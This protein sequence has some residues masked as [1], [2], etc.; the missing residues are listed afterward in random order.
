MTKSALFVYGGWGGHEPKHSAEIVCGWL[1][2]KNWKIELS[3]NLEIFTDSQT[4]SSFD[5]IVPVWTGGELSKEQES[6]LESAV[7][8]GIGLAGWHGMADAFGN[9][10][11]Y[12]MAVGGRFVWHPANDVRINIKII[13]PNDPIMQGIDDFSIT[14]ELYYMHID[15]SNH[16]L[17]DCEFP[18]DELGQPQGVRMPVAWRRNWGKGR[19][20]YF[21]IGHK[22]DDLNIAQVRRIIEQ[23]LLWAA[24]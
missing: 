8:N 23:G 22:P 11:I 5:L 14:S 16:I 9:S 12:K 20:F 2:E 18:A 7:R 17:A 15:P 3:D 19:V 24:K 4:L 13:E 10:Q 21:S 1:K 6:G